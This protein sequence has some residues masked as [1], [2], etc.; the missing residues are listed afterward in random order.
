MDYYVILWQNYHL[1]YSINLFN[2]YST[3]YIWDGA[4]ESIQNGI[5]NIIHMNGFI[6]S[7]WGELSYIRQNIW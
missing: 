7:R 2:G 5:Q 3:V 4:N 1:I 6:S